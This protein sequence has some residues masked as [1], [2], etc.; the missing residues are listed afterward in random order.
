MLDT[1]PS[2]EVE[3]LQR[4]FDWV[5]QHEVNTFIHL[6]WYYKVFLEKI[7]YQ[8]LIHVFVLFTS[9]I[10]NYKLTA[11]IQTKTN[12]LSPIVNFSRPENSPHPPWNNPLDQISKG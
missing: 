3:S 7:R 6:Y 5:L 2:E 11:K 4:E 9:K 8:V 12:Q 10:G 1:R